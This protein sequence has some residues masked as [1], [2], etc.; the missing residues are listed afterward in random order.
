MARLRVKRIEGFWGH[1][2]VS[3]SLRSL[4]ALNGRKFTEQIFCGALSGNKAPAS[5][6]ATRMDASRNR[7][8]ASPMCVGRM[9]PLHV[10]AGSG[11]S[12]PDCRKF[13]PDVRSL[14]WD[15]ILRSSNFRRQDAAAHWGRVPP[16]PWRIHARS[17]YGCPS[18]CSAHHGFALTRHKKMFRELPSVQCLQRA[19]RI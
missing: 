9:P 13:G 2:T 1:G 3:N 19:Q 18:L 5:I 11:P 10:T 4:Y 12:M 7:L 16:V 6:G 17:A 14:W 15:R 8:N